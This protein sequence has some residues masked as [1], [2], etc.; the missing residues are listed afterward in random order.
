MSMI[1]F[2]RDKTLIAMISLIKNW[3]WLKTLFL[4]LILA[5]IVK[6]SPKRTKWD[7]SQSAPKSF[8]KIIIINVLVAT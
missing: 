8:K 4:K 6:M 2:I 5:S 1:W 7:N 3:D